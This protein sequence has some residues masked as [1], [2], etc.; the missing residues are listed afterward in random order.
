MNPCSE[1][2]SATL[3][4]LRAWFAQA[5]KPH[6]HQ[7]DVPVQRGR[8]IGERV[9]SRA[10]RQP[11]AERREPDAARS[12]GGGSGGPH[13]AVLPRPLFRRN[14]QALA[15]VLDEVRQFSDMP[16]GIQLVPRGAQ[17][18]E[19]GA[20]ARRSADRAGRRR[21]AGY[22]VRRSR[23]RTVNWRRSNSTAPAWNTSAMRS[24]RVRSVPSGW[25]SRY[26][27]AL[28]SRLS[29][30]INFSAGG[31]PAQRR[32]RRLDLKPHAFPAEIY[33]AVR[34]VWPGA[35]RLACAFPQHPLVE[36]RS[37]RRSSL[38][39]VCTSMAATGLMYR[40]AGFRRTKKFRLGPITRFRLPVRCARRLA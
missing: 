15:D 2:T 37:S 19:R 26:R 14:E 24:S 18:V 27:T 6:H 21:L 3:F 22:G 36:R 16:I 20:L 32:I 9:A 7:P 8:R 5:A 13:H 1:S 30:C 17:G 39:S 25:V 29:A 11:V 35:S 31:E 34:A 10:Y 23:R 12:D 33:D 4:L 40:R 28:C 38:R